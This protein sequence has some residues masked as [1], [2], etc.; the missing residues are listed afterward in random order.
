MILQIFRSVL[1]M[2]LS[3]TM[4]AFFLL[5][6][7]LIMQK[8]GCPR[9]ITFFLWIAIAFRLVCPF[10]PSCN[11]NPFSLLC[12]PQITKHITTGGGVVY[13]A[14]GKQTP[15]APQSAFADI[16][17]A[18]A[19]IWICVLAV[20]N[21]LAAVSYIRLRRRLRFAVKL[22]DNIYVCEN[23]PSSFVL[24]MIRPRIFISS[25]TSDDIICDI[26]AHE[27]MHISRR[28]YLT[29]PLAHLILTVHWFN[30]A[31]W[32]MFRL[33]S[34]DAEMACDE[35]VLKKCAVDKSHYLSS[36]LSAATEKRC[37][38]TAFAVSFSDTTKKRIKNIIS[39]KTQTAFSCAVRI[40]LCVLIAAVS[41]TNPSKADL[42]KKAVSFP[43]AA[44]QVIKTQTA[45]ALRT[46]NTL[47]DYIKETPAEKDV[48]K[49]PESDAVIAEPDV[50][51]TETSEID[52]GV[53][54]PSAKTEFL[55]SRTEKTADTSVD[56]TKDYVL[57]SFD[58]T[59]KLC[60]KIESIK[61]DENGNITLYLD[62][63]FASLV[64]VTF[65]DGANGDEI[66]S[67]TAIS[68]ENTYTYTGFDK[69]KTYSI[70]LSG[71]TQGDWKININYTIC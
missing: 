6:M 32:V 22:K 39:Q 14:V 13:R 68:N 52:F 19:V 48:S 51:P 1:K 64:D 2:S 44:S 71:K 54:E 30:P 10:V 11:A 70:L 56:L 38:V 50:I 37:Y 17:T 3:A 35:C 49:P 7:K 41:V 24:G 58:Y 67:F 61:P 9:R 62:A 28:D 4:S 15:V 55:Q 26:I 66:A 65:C 45:D 20:M 5:G 23:A 21:C 29:K 46:E 69:E 60:E 31:V 36:V 53:S 40:V 47:K 25:N 27:K 43:K 12:K 57:G 16:E 33:F 34:D 8:T 63:D 59:D 42:P 18:A